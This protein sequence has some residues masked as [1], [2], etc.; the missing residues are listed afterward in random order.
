MSHGVSSRAQYAVR[1]WC[2]A[3][4]NHLALHL[5]SS[6]RLAARPAPTSSYGPREIASGFMREIASGFMQTYEAILY[7]FLTG[8]WSA[9]LSSQSNDHM[10]SHVGCASTLPKR[11]SSTAALQFEMRL[12]KAWPQSLHASSRHA[13]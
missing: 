9:L 5:A 3:C 11:I 12:C 10:D 13:P 7:A 2:T 6:V 8:Q 1:V 4:L